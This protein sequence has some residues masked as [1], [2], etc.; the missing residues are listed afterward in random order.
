MQADEKVPGMTAPSKLHSVRLMWGGRPRP[1]RPPRSGFR[2]QADETSAAG[3][4]PAPQDNLI[5]MALVAIG[6]YTLLMVAVPL[7]R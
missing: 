7:G 2:A 1:R 4:G 6:P 3:L 5:F